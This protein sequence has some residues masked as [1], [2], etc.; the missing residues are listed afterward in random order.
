M[1]ILRICLA[2]LLILNT[3]FCVSAAHNEP[4]FTT[5]TIS[6]SLP[7]AIESP[8]VSKCAEPVHIEPTTESD[9]V[10]FDFYNVPLDIETQL[11]VKNACAFYEFD[12]KLIY[13]ICY[14]ESGFNADNNV[15]GNPCKGI[16]AI[17]T[18]YAPAYFECGDRFDVL[19]EGTFEPH[20]PKQNIILGI[21][22]LD[23][24]RKVCKSRGYKD[25][26]SVLQCY[27]SGFSYFKNPGKFGY[28]NW[29]LSTEINYI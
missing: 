29:V 21:R 18:K 2:L 3:L 5:E 23:Y 10:V 1:K 4:C 11:L 7:S 28:A 27:N 12:E 22:M 9:T 8:I 25:I 24:W 15:L 14:R 16:M 26:R 17:S 19:F 6:Q 20:N 13:Q